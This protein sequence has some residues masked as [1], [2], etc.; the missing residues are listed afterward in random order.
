[1]QWHWHF[2]TYS[3]IKKYKGSSDTQLRVHLHAI[4]IAIVINLDASCKR[5]KIATHYK[6]RWNH[7]QENGKK[8]SF[9]EKNAKMPA[10]FTDTLASPCILS[11]SFLQ[12]MVS[13]F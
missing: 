13:T 8:V 12:W 3:L 1:M 2:C 7:S 4:T 10:I 6:C 11:R 9:I 5:Q